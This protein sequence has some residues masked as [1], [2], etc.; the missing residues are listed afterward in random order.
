M[1][2]DH[3]GLR[4]ILVFASETH[5]FTLGETHGKGP[6]LFVCGTE[7]ASVETQLFPKIEC[8]RPTH[9]T[10]PVSRRCILQRPTVLKFFIDHERELVF[11][12][13]G[14]AVH[15]PSTVH[16]DS[17]WRLHL[18]RR[19]RIRRC[20]TTVHKAPAG[21]RCFHQTALPCADV[22]ISHFKL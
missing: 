14:I 1:R 5:E 19:K 15:G 18:R 3:D 16:Q 17:L 6:A 4:I 22:L 2:A 13:A 11:R 7:D 8:A 12:V 10:A 9:A 21:E 20:R